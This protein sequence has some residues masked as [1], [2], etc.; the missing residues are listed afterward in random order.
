MANSLPFPS[1]KMASSS[2]DIGD[3]NI[4]ITPTPIALVF[5]RQDRT[6]SRKIFSYPGCRDDST[7]PCQLLTSSSEACKKEF[8]TLEIP[9]YLEQYCMCTNDYYA[10]SSELVTLFPLNNMLNENIRYPNSLSIPKNQM[11]C[12][13]LSLRRHVPRYRINKPRI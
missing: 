12:R 10:R 5:G 3:Q 4:P 1:T 11:L 13:L 8:T 7:G 6:S 9:F 2:V